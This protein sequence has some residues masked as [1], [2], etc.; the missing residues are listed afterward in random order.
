[1]KMF[2]ELRFE[3]PKWL[4]YFAYVLCSDGFFLF[5]MLGIRF[6]RYKVTFTLSALIRPERL[7]YYLMLELKRNAVDI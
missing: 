3:Q 5:F 2:F 4:S 1:M 7:S 6:W